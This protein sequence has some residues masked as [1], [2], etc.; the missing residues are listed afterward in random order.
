MLQSPQEPKDPLLGLEFEWD[1]SIVYPGTSR[2]FWIHVP[3]QYDPAAP[4]ALMVFQD[5]RLYLDP[6]GD[7]RGGI[8]LDNLIHDGRIP[9]TIGVFVDPG[10]VA[11]AET[12]RT[13]TSNT[14][15]SMT[16][17]PHSF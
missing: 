2:K 15:R 8:V 17:T 11:D 9:V 16:A 1:K 4:A 13:E 6:E 12:L 3:A 10:V 14:T 7:V 5:G